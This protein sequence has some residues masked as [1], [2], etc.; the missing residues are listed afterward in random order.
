MQVGG[1]ISTPATDHQQPINAVRLELAGDHV[2]VGA[3]RDLTIGPQLGPTHRD[4]A[5]HAHPV[6]LLEVAVDEALEGILNRQHG[7]PPVYA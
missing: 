6:H 3:F 1:L 4:P 5:R 7:V 2:K